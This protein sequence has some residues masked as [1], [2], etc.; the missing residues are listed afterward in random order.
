MRAKARKSEERR[1]TMPNNYAQ[2]LWKIDK[3]YGTKKAFYEAA[4][5]SSKT[6][7]GY[8]KGETPMPATFISKACEL[9]SIPREEIGLYFFTPDAG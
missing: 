9:L 3:A 1:K 5:I 2:L 8:I 4:G 7:D 6:F